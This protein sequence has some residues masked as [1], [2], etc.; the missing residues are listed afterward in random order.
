MEWAKLA[1]TIIPFPTIVHFS[2]WLTE[3]ANVVCTIADVEGK[4]PRRRLLHASTDHNEG[5]QQGPP[6]EV[7]QFLEDNMQSGTAENSMELR[8]RTVGDM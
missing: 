5:Y 2:V 3:Y 1:A 6:P 4:E 8:H 7:V